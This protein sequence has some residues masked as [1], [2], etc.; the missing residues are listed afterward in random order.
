MNTYQ[1]VC[2]HKPKQNRPKS[3]NSWT[4]WK[5]GTI[6]QLY[7][8]LL[9][10]HTNPNGAFP[11]RRSRMAHAGR[12]CSLR[13]SISVSEISPRNMVLRW[14]K[15]EETKCIFTYFYWIQP[16]QP[17]QPSQPRIGWSCFLWIGLRQNVSRIP[18]DFPFNE[19]GQQGSLHKKYTDF[20]RWPVQLGLQQSD[21]VK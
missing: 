6:W 15:H 4:F 17:S 8:D 18:A 20:D 5:S 21:I 11:L 16:I 2:S 19:L 10:I 13:I 14:R 1:H 7:G 3:L 12:G 9:Q